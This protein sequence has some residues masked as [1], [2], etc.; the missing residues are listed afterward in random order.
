[1]ADN[2]TEEKGL[3]T[4]HRER[5]REEFL[6]VGFNA[7]T[8]DH[9]MLEMLL[10]HCIPR[11]DTNPLAHELLNRFGSLAGVLDAP[12]EE[13]CKLPM[14]TRSN[15]T[16]LKLIMPIARR[17]IE[18]K[19]WEAPDF[20]DLN[21]IGE[22]LLDCY[23]GIK[24]ERASLVYL[25]AM[26]KKLSFEFISTGSVDSV[27]L[28]IKDIMRRVLDKGAS[29]VVLAHN[30]P[31][32]IA[33]PSRNDC[34]LTEMI[35]DMLRRMEVPLLDHIILSDTDFVSMAQSREYSHIFIKSE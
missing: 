13:L 24:E 11:N 30:H 20:K 35:A 23:A 8:P 33:L 12:I 18:L 31:S 16:L 5:M 6:N 25:S 32:G 26:G 28:S 14:L 4:G 29:A 3:H 21:E 17:Y 34:V 27:G 10:F 19:D 9:K 2:S 1:M 15:A 7:Y 22:Y